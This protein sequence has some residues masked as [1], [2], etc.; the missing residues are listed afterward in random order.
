MEITSPIATTGL[1]TLSVIVK[2]FA[3]HQIHVLAT[4][5]DTTHAVLFRHLN[6]SARANL[7]TLFQ[8]GAINH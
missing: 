6:R 5:T 3:Q 1:F 8:A 7:V 2:L 4:F